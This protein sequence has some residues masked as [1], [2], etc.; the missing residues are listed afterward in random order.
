MQI[1]QVLREFFFTLESR[2]LNKQVIIQKKELTAAFLSL[3]SML[4][5]PPVFSL[6]PSCST[7]QQPY[8]CQEGLSFSSI[9]LSWELMIEEKTQ[10]KRKAEKK[11]RR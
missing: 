6:L 8:I 2:I 4:F 9:Y 3:I 1:I 11:Y 10:K 5:F 7:L